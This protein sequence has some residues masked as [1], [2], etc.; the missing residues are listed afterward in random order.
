MATKDIKNFTKYPSLSDNDYLLGTKTDLGGTDAGI[1]VGDFKKQVASDAAPSINDNGYWVVNGVS[2]GQKAIGET[3]V[4]ESGTTT[5]GDAGT[6][7]SAEVIASGTT[8][9]GQPRYKINL[10]I[11]R[12]SD[13]NPGEDGNDGK[14]V[15]LQIGDV[16]K[17][18]TPS[19]TLTPGGTDTSGNPIYKLDLVLPKGDKGNDGTDGTDGSDGKTPKFEA[20]TVTTL[21]PGE[22]ASATITFKENDADG[23]PIYTISL[24]LPKGDTGDDGVDGK[25]PVFEIGT[26]EKGTNA[27]ATVTANGT[28]I[29]GNPKYSINLVLPKGDTGND[30]T[31][32]TDGSDGKT[33][34]FETGTVTTGNPG[35]AASATVEFVGTTDEGY[36]RYKINMTVPRGQQG[37]PGE[38]SG[39]VSA[40]GAGLIIGRKYLFVPDSDGSTSG[41]FIEYVPQEQV[42]P[43]WNATEGKGA[44]L[45]KPTI[46]TKTSELANDSGYTTSTAVAELLTGYVQK[47]AGKGLSTED[48]TTELKNKLAGLNNYDDTDIQAAVT[49]LQNQLDTL[50]SGNASTAIESFNEIIA[51][52]ANVEDSQTLEGII[53]GINTTIADVR[54]S[55]PTKLSQLT[56]DDNT[57]K[58]ANY[59]HTDNNYTAADKDKLTGVADNANNYVHPTTA[60]YKHIPAGGSENQIL[61]WSADGTAVWTDNE[62]GDS[63]VE[64]Y[65]VPV[66]DSAKALWRASGIL[67]ALSDIESFLGPL[68][69]FISAA[70]AGKSIYFVSNGGNVTV[71]G[72][73]VSADGRTKKITFTTEWP[74]YNGNNSGVFKLTTY[75]SYLS[76]SNCS[77]YNRGVFNGLR[78]PSYAS[79]SWTAYITGCPG[80]ITTQT[81][82]ILKLTRWFFLPEHGSTTTLIVSNLG[83]TD[84]TITLQLDVSASGDSSTLVVVG[85]NPVTIPAGQSVEISILWANW[86]YYVRC[87]EPF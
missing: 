3:P 46:P 86:K 38:G 81:N 75:L 69:D 34:V 20:G 72:L 33:P 29:S 39:N 24:S 48:F 44:I 87:S 68:A 63:A 57:V 54:T 22:Q 82:D 30:G 23:S 16:T 45:N 28:D 26:V 59:V 56:N 4:L 60:G 51:F 42:Q 71:N 17:G 84:I 5:T 41:S 40:S 47:V 64:F 31:D 9:G 18:D 80:V 19:A 67:S 85:D 65:K 15:Q 66:T 8:E 83:S 43:D 50:L 49:S 73:E 52:L 58:D 13:G 12:G 7:A 53:A 25:T 27:S 70:E 1:A 35:T 6:E 37:L 21:N 10:V 61:K 79:G 2:T 76:D 32:G 36:P 77:M 55:I 78:N 11:P 62:G 74:C 14:T